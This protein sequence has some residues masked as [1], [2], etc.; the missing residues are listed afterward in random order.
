[1]TDPENGQQNLRS[2]INLGILQLLRDNGVEIP[3]PQRV[4]HTR[5]LPEDVAPR[6]S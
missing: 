4:I 5:P 1:M 3:Y 6:P 2:R